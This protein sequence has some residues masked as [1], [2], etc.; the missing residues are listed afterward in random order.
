MRRLRRTAALSQGPKSH[1]Q[2][3]DR[4]SAG[5]VRPAVELYKLTESVSIGKKR[6]LWPSPLLLVDTAAA[7]LLVRCLQPSAQVAPAR[8][9]PELFP[10]ATPESQAQ[11]YRLAAACH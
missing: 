3:A 2:S 11:V 1:V 6:Q 5:L 10:N 4:W 8:A 7:G 9:D